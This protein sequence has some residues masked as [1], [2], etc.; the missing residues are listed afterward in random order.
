MVLQASEVR[1][2]EAKI[3]EAFGYLFEPARYKVAEGGR[4]SAK[5][6]SYADALLISGMDTQLRILCAREIMESLKESVH[7]LLSDRIAALGL[8]EFYDVTKTSITG[9]N[10]TNF[11]FAGLFR[12]VNQ[13]KSLEG[14]DRVWVEEAESVSK[15][16][17]DLLIPTIRK[18][19]SEIWVTYNPQFEDDDTYIRFHVNPPDGAVV[20]QI[21]YDQNPYF[22][23]VLLKDMEQDKARDKAKYETVWLGQPKGGGRRVWPGFTKE[24]HVRE[25]PMEFI[26]KKGNCYMAM[27]PHSKYYPFV[28]WI[29]VFPKNGRGKWP[30]DFHKHV[31]AEWP[32]IEEIGGNYHDLR[33]KLMYAGTLADVARA[34]Y[35]HDGTEYGIT[36]KSRL[37]DPRY[38]NGAGGWNWSTSTEGLVELFAK[39]ENGGMLLELPAIKILDAQR[40]VLHSDMLWNQNAERNQFNEPSFSVSPKCKNVISSLLNHRLEAETDKEDERYKDPSDAL[41]IGWAGIDEW[42]DPEEVVIPYSI[43]VPRSGWGA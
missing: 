32:T 2:I 26:A 33:K 5:S 10:G 36:I 24:A 23:D 16:S 21:N 22:P 15:E 40:E 37:A 17:W 39:K 12:N 28:V 3:P 31:Y 34:C 8:E 38:A 27:D 43:R 9:Q 29:A 4:G 35:A 13:I 42:K 19:G 6:W 25:F 7:R 20:R 14:I 1:Q 18:D 41:R 11:I 30:E